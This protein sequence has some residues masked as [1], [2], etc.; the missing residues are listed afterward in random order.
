MKRQLD[1]GVELNVKAG[2]FHGTWD[3]KVSRHELIWIIQK[4]PLICQNWTEL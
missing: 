1:A 2:P 3:E 4:F